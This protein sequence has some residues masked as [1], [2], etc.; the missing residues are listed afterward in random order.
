MWIDRERSRVGVDH[1]SDLLHSDLRENECPSLSLQLNISPS[2][3]NRTNTIAINLLIAH[4]TNHPV[5]DSISLTLQIKFYDLLVL[6]SAITT[7]H[8][9]R[10]SAHQHSSFSTLA[11][12]ARRWFV[13]FL[14]FSRAR[15]LL[16]LAATRPLWQSFI[17]LYSGCSQYIDTNRRQ[18][19]RH[20]KQEQHSSSRKEGSDASKI[21]TAPQ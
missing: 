5:F 17:T 15:L 16:L 7:M 10:A 20:N 4:L 11:T 8:S 13:L 19:E 1:S 21:N 6:G 9:V 2:A 12:H 3:L 14:S 18:S